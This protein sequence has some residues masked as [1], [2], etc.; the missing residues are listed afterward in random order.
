MFVDEKVDQLD[1][2][3]CKRTPSFPECPAG[4]Y[5]DHCSQTCSI[6]CAGDPRV[7]DPFNGTCGSCLPGFKGSKCDQGTYALE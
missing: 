6:N 4:T 7:C 5:G 1:E 2:S 3:I